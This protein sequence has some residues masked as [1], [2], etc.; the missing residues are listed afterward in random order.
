MYSI[1]LASVEIMFTIQI[2]R[3]FFISKLLLSATKPSCP[4]ATDVL[5]LLST[6]IIIMEVGVHG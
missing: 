1:K 2:A 6:R 3:H 5:L 4:S